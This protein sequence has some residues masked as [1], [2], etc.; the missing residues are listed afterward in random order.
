MILRK[1]MLL[2]VSLLILSCKGDNDDMSEPNDVIN[3]DLTEGIIFGSIDPTGGNVVYRYTDEGVFLVN[4]SGSV[5]SEMVW[6]TGDCPF[7]EASV[8]AGLTE[9]VPN[10]ARG[11]RDID[12]TDITETLAEGEPFFILEYVT[13]ENIKTIQFTRDSSFN[14]EQIN[15][16]FSYIIG[17]LAI[18]EL[19]DEM[20]LSLNN[21]ICQ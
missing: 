12:S 6:T 1:L 18:L 13:S 8:T 17:T 20:P 5:T 9:G 4:N 3:V 7:S 10:L 2:V 15:T 19:S 11:I 14:E 21:E 16:Y